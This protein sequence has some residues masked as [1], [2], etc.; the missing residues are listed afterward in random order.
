MFPRFTNYIYA[1]LC[2][3]LF[4]LGST[5]FLLADLT[6]FIYF[7]QQDFRYLAFV[8]NFFINLVGSVLYLVGS[9]LFI[10]EAMHFYLGI[11]MF[12]AGAFMVMAAQTWKLLRALNQP[13]KTVKQSFKD[14]SIAVILDFLAAF[15]AFFYFLGSFFL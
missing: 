11:H 4:T 3:W 13:N 6:E 1:E 12:I 7:L 15:G 2:G 8:I 9:I 10:P 14:G 5:C